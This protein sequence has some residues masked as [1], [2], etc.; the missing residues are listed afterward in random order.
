[1]NSTIPRVQIYKLTSYKSIFLCKKV[2]F[3]RS[4]LAHNLIF[5][6]TW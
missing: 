5:K 6:D 3:Y 1:M 2:Y 4:K